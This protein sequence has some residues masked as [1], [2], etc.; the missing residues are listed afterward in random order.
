MIGLWRRLRQA[1]RRDERRLDELAVEQ[2]VLEREEQE[3]RK[4]DP[5]VPIPPLRSDAD[6]GGR[7]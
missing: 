4:A 3:R 7:S 5:S 1:W 2:A 6:W